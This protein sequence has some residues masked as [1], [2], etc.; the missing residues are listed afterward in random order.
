[1][2]MLLEAVRTQ[3]AML[4]NQWAS[5]DQWSTVSQLLDQPMDEGAAGTVT[6]KSWTCVHCTFINAANLTS[7]EI[8][9]LPH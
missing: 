3:N 5:S 1:M 9:N 8:C 4:A 7:C 2:E 6:G